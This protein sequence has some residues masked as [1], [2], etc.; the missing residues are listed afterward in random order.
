M[1]QFLITVAGVLTGLFVFLFVGPVLLIMLVASSVN[2][3][4]AQPNRMVLALDLRESMSDQRS[5]N[6]WANLS[7]G[8][9]LL[10]LLARIESARTDNRVQGLYIRANTDG[11]SA[12]HAEELRD[13]LARFRESGKFVIAHV[14]PAG[15]RLSMAGFMAIADSDQIWMQEAG[16]VPPMGL[17][18]E[19]TFFGATLRRYH[20]QA[21]FEAREEYKTFA[22]DLTQTAFTPSHRE[23]TTSLMTGLYDTMLAHIA[24]DRGITP[25]QVRAAIE[26][27]PM[28]A[29]R[30]VELRL[31]DEL[32]RPEAAAHAALDRAGDNTQMVDFDDYVARPQSRSGPVIAVVQGEGPIVTGEAEPTIFGD[33]PMMMSDTISEALLD[34]ARDENVRAIIFRV[35]SPGG[36]VVASDQILAALRTARERGKIVVVSMGEVAASGGYYVSTHANEIIASPTTITGSIGVVSGKLIIGDAL[37]H[38]LSANTETISM[39]SPLVNMYSADRPF[40]QAE[41]AAHAATVDRMYA[42][43]IALVADGRGMQPAQ[44]REVARG[45]VWT[46]QQALERGLVDYLGGFSV[47]LARARE[48]A[49]IEADAHVQLRFYPQEQNP[50]ESF[51][52]L[53]STTGESVQALVRLNQMLSDPRMVRAMRAIREEEAGVRAEA[54]PMTVR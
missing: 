46:G 25:A 11:L 6:P 18:S 9:A 21:D 13:A 54:A 47:A 14:Q 39:G 48:L 4:P 12:A 24:A 45:R 38:Y 22:N 3:A 15:I 28:P 43:F 36:S 33:D 26:A 23:A 32:G 19:V 10:D 34:A 35:S 1:K 30:A 44:V 52:R 5:P 42:Q 2:Q 40:N 7:G 53:F 17:S 29:A 51:S 49:G 31:V 16:E 41:R 20:L 50:F 8:H 27:T 37:E